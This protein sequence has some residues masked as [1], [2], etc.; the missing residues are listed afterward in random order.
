MHTQQYPSDSVGA[1]ELEDA[2]HRRQAGKRA[3][4][5]PVLGASLAVALALGC[6]P[7]IDGPPFDVLIYVLDTCRADRIGTYGYQRPTTPA[8]DA[9]AADPDA[10]VYMH[11]YVAGNWTKPATASLFTGAH[12]HQHGVTNTHAEA[13]GASTRLRRPRVAEQGGTGDSDVAVA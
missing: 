4:R 1:H 2:V 5:C 3:S 11:N 13:D 6:G 8:I 10:V 9:L 12:V 7:A